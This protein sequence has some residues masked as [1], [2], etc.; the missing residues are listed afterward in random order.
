MPTGISDWSL[1]AVVDS[2]LAG[3]VGLGP[4]GNEDG[5]VASWTL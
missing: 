4:V 3:R 5:I 2:W 1:I